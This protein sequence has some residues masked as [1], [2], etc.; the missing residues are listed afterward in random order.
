M[1]LQHSPSIVTSGL[2]MCL[3]AGNPRSYAGAGTQWRDASGNTNNG[4]LINGVGYNSSNLGTLVF[5]GVNDY[6]SIANNISLRPTT[7][8]TIEYVIKGTTPTGWCPVLG[9]G[10]GDYTNGNYLVWVENGGPLQSLCRVSNNGVIEYRQSSG[11]NISSSDFKYMSFTM[12]I[13]DAMRSYYNGTSTGN[14][15]SLPAGGI[16]HYGGTV[17]PYQIVGLGGAWLNG[18]ISMIRLY[19]KALTATEVLQNFNATRG[20]YGI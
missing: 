12:K 13:G 16:F 1:A 19:N 10:N 6:V 4:T 5:D 18:S 14:V 7:E 2:V 15:I 3:D 11:E 20:R 17:S 9:Y 8:L